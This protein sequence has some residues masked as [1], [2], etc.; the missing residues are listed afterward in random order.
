MHRKAPRCLQYSFK[1]KQLSLIAGAIEEPQIVDFQKVL[2]DA[3]PLAQVCPGAR[4][5]HCAEFV[6]DSGRLTL[7]V[8]RLTLDLE[9]ASVASV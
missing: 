4:P 9:P 5:W 7:V 1:R 2:K 3:F 6:P 8:H